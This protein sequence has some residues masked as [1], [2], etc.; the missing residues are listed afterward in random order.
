MHN[1]M[2]RDGGKMSGIRSEGV[3]HIFCLI[4]RTAPEII[5][6]GRVVRPEIDQ[7]KN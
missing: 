1:F 6:A 4:A 5:F 3:G 7:P 2:G